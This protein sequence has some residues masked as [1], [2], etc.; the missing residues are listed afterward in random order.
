M[1]ARALSLFTFVALALVAG[2]AHA[3]EPMTVGDFLVAIVQAEGG[4]A[5]DGAAARGVLDA[6]GVSLPRLDL[7]AGL[8]ESHV[9]LVSRH[10]GL[11]VATTRPDAPFDGEQTA[12]FV[13][14]FVDE[15]DAGGASTR[16]ED[17]GEDGDDGQGPGFDPFTKGKGSA[18]G[19]GKMPPISP[20]D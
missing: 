18:K 1:K 16:G 7:G 15:W 6:R 8:T 12:R 2:A 10:L 17:D 5:A 9:V 19:K 20:I 11:R 3:A 13:A 14:A 4:S